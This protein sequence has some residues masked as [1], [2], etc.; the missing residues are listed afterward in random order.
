MPDPEPR[1]GAATLR[2]GDEV[3]IVADRLVYGGECRAL[4]PGGDV[5]LA[6]G[7]IP[8]EPCR[9]RLARR[10]KGVWFGSVVGVA[11]PSPLRRTPPCRFAGRCGGCQLQH[12]EDSVQLPM[13]RQVVLDLLRHEKVPLPD[14]I[15]DHPASNPF[16]YRRRGEFHVLREAGTTSLGFNEHRRWTQVAIDDCLIHHADIR[17]SLPQMRELAEL[18][19]GMRSIH[20]TAG[21]EELLI[22]GKPESSWNEEA[23]DR[24]A[25]APGGRPWSVSGTTL[26]WRGHVF[27]VTPETFLQVNLT[28]MDVLY[29]T[30]LDD[31]AVTEGRVLDAYAGI[32]VLA[33]EIASQGREVMLVESNA[34]SVA[35]GRLAASMNGVEDRIEFLLAPLEDASLAFGSFGLV[36]LDPPR[37]GCDAS[38]TTRLALDPAPRVTYVSC[39]PSTLARDLRVLVRLGPYDLVRLDCVDMFPQTYHV[40]TVAHLARK[41]G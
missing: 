8:G 35:L 25:T 4:L 3:D 20:V 16:G 21:D 10:S 30:V 34:A 12:I 38:V 41:P 28:M 18:S 13:K 17:S 14:D 37:A 23:A 26:S 29:Q 1:S 6:A 31:V 19:P 40:E 36:L 33:T 22:R 7:A 11:E 24:L 32:G 15:R 39:N 9:I 2:P 27:R 5:V